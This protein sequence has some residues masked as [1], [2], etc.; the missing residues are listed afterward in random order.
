MGAA[1]GATKPSDKDS[2]GR[3][4][5]L[6][7]LYSSILLPASLPLIGLKGQM[8]TNVFKGMRPHNGHDDLTA[9]GT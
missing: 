4:F 6:V 9:R 3:L 1:L 5:G 2:I 8:H 7:L